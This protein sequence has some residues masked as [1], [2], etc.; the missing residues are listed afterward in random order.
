MAASGDGVRATRYK[1]RGL[2]GPADKQ[3][4]WHHRKAAFVLK[5]RSEVPHKTEVPFMCSIFGIQS[6]SV[7]PALL[8]ACFDRTASRGSDMS[9]M[10]EIPCD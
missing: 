8:Q 3:I 4:R 2:L 10:V 1:R 9:R 7:D 5:F 6:K